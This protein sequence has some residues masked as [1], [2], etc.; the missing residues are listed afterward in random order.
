MYA[1]WKLLAIALVVVTGCRGGH[2]PLFAAP[3]TKEAQQRRAVVHDPYPQNDIAPPLPDG[4]PRDYLYPLA[5]P[6]RTRAVA[7]AMPWLGR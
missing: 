6:V 3:G 1:N 7:D 5:E 2:G 4:R